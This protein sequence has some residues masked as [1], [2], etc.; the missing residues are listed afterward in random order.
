MTIE[1][2]TI[3]ATNNLTAEVKE[4]TV[5]KVFG[6]KSDLIQDLAAQWGVCW[7]SISLQECVALYAEG[8]RAI[9]FRFAA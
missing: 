9:T 3:R 7:D 2:I 4:V 1:T 6:W 8:K 5:Q